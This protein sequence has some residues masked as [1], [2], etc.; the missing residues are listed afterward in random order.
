MGYEKIKKSAQPFTLTSVVITIVL[1]AGLF[2]G[3][4]YFIED[5]ATNAG[6]VIDSKYQQSF[7]R[8][9][10]S[11]TGLSGNIDDIR[12]NLEDVAE[13]DNTFQVAWNGLKG[14]GNTLKLP[15]SFIDTSINTFT[16]FTGLGL[17]PDWAMLLIQ[18]AI[19]GAL[20]FLVL[21]VLKGEPR[22]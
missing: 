21:S 7:D 10:E 1:I 4:Y 20:A 12:L 3:G 6:T 5:S 11:T 2:Y 22:T 16:A 9:N 17:L 14:L 8:L 13:A 19:I 15:L 18:I